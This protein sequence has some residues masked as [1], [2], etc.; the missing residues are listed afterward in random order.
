MDDQLKSDPFNIM[1]IKESGE[2]IPAYCFW[3]D[4]HEEVCADVKEWGYAAL[5]L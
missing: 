2:D 3:R 4:T 5:V 1:K